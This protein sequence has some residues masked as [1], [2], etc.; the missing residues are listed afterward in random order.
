SHHST[1]PGAVQV[2][3]RNVNLDSIRYRMDRR[4]MSPAHANIDRTKET[5]GTATMRLNTY[6]VDSGGT[7][8]LSAWSE[9]LTRGPL[10]PRLRTLLEA[11]VSQINGCAFC[12]AMHTEEARAAE[13]PQAML[14]SLAAWRDDAAYTD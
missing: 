4:H 12:L 6:A 9:H 1:V 5:R 7:K 13:V 2:S 8:R 14:D 10:S 11:R 3:C